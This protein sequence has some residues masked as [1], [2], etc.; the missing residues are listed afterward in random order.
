[1]R[2]VVIITSTS[3]LLW[4]REIEPSKVKEKKKGKKISIA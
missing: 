2:V 1:M 4:E 3:R